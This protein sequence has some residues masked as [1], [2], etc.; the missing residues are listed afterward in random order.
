MK[1]QETRQYVVQ[2]HYYHK[3][4]LKEEQKERNKKTISLDK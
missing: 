1:R 2:S 3:E 4:K